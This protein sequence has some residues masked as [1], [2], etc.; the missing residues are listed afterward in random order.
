MLFLRIVLGI[1]FTI[2]GIIGSILPIMQGW[3]FFLLAFLVLFPKSK[4]AIK[5]LEKVEKR[6]PRLVAWL[7]KMGVGTA[8]AQSTIRAE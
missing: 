4:L 3:V 7:R 8:P 6:A 1:V 5:A 2:L